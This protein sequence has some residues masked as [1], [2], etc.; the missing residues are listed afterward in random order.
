MLGR[1][2]FYITLNDSRFFFPGDTLQG[3]VTLSLDKPTKTNCIRVT[4]KGDVEA[5]GDSVNLFTKQ[6]K[7]ASDAIILEART[8]TFPFEFL[9]D[10]NLNLPSS[11]KLKR[12]SIVYVLTAIHERPLIPDALSLKTEYPLQILEN[13]NAELPEF[14]HEAEMCQDVA[15]NGSADHS[16]KARVIAK[17]PRFAFVRGDIIPLELTIKHV[18]KVTRQKAIKVELIR[19]ALFGKSKNQQPVQHSIRSLQIDLDISSDNNTFTTSPRLLV[20]SS[21]PPTIDLNGKI[22]S[23]QYQVRISITLDSP[24]MV[25]S[26]AHDVVLEIPIVVAT[27]PP[28]TVPIDLDLENLSEQEE[29]SDDLEGHSQQTSDTEDSDSNDQQLENPGK[30]L[31]APIATRPLRTSSLSHHA[32]HKTPGTAP[33]VPAKPMSYIAP[34]VTEDTA[35]VAA[36]DK[37]PISTMPTTPMFDS[38][39]ASPAVSQTQSPTP[40]AFNDQSSLG[41]SQD[42][43]S[44]LHVRD[45]SRFQSLSHM[46]SPQPSSPSISLPVM[47]IPTIVH[48]NDSQTGYPHSYPLEHAPHYNLQPFNHQ[49]APHSMQMPVASNYLSTASSPL[50]SSCSGSPTNWNHTSS[51]YDQAGYQWNQSAPQPNHSVQWNLPVTNNRQSDPY[52]PQLQTESD[53]AYAPFTSSMPA[54]SPNVVMPTPDNYYYHHQHQQYSYPPT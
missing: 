52:Y 14:A 19:I 43:P 48:R 39:L 24:G 34:I 30:I 9:V 31:P 21:T 38:G 2:E 18:T 51:P 54:S 3:T 26:K 50:S 49:S 16:R 22:L 37:F 10:K 44:Q 7:L 17:M 47:P 6:I 32:V 5:N 41:R 12:G 35:T 40:S 20:P 28:A 53:P 23:V 42:E 13:I 45:L 46:P 27:W 25:L 33:V 1:G 4:F 8:H 15:V 11:T 36:S 29:S